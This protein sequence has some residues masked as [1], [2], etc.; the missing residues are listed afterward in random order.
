MKAG[1][2]REIS[3]K[4]RITEIGTD[5]NYSRFLLIIITYCYDPDFPQTLTS[6]RKDKEYS[7][8]GTGVP[9]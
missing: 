1:R 3:W 8:G 2:K 7:A 9:G 5:L 4:R 6:R